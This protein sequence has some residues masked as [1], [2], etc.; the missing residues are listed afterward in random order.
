MKTAFSRRL[1]AILLVAAMCLSVMPVMVFAESKIDTINRAFTG[2]SGTSYTGFSGKVSSGSG[3]TYAGQCAGGNDSVQLRSSKSNSGIV[4][5]NSVGKAKTIEVVWNTNTTAGRTLDVYG[6]NTPYTSATELYNSSTQGTKIGSI[7]KGTSVKLDITGDYAYIGLRSNNGAMY[8]DS[9]SI[10][11]DVPGGTTCN[12]DNKT[13][14]VTAEATC[15][16]EGEKKFTCPDCNATWTEAIA[17]QDH[18]YDEGVVTKDPTCTE[19]GVKTYTCSVCQGTRTEAILATGHTDTDNDSVCDVCN[20]NLGSEPSA[21]DIPTWDSSEQNYTNQEAVTSAQIADGIT[22][23]FDKGT[24]SNAPKYYTS[25]TAIRCY[26]G[27]SFTVTSTKGNITKIV[28]GFGSGDGTNAITADSGTLSGDT[29][30][31]SADSVKFTIGG[32]S[33]NRRIQTI[34]VTVAGTTEGGGEGGG[35]THVHAWDAGTVTT[36]ATCTEDGVKTFTCACGQTRTEA[37]LA[38]GHTDTDNDSVCDV[39]NANLG[40]EP[41]GETATF[42]KVTTAPT[43]WSGTYLIV[44]EGHSV[45]LDGTLTADQAKNNKSVTISSNKIEADPAYSFSVEKYGENYAIK[46]ASGRYIYGTSGSNHLNYDSETAHEVTIDLDLAT[47]DVK[48]GNSG[49]ALRY[50]KTSGQERFRFYDDGSQEAIQLYK[51]VEPSEGA[52]LREVSA[53]L[54]GD[55][56][57]NYYITLPQ[58]VTD[59]TGAYVQFTVNGKPTKIMVNSISSPETDGSYKFTYRMNAKEMHDQVTFAVYDGS[60]NMIDL[61]STTG[62]KVE[63]SSFVYSLADYFKELSSDTSPEKAA[64]VNLAN[65][66]LA[67]GSYVQKAF[68]YDVPTADSVMDISGVTIDTLAAHKMIK[69]GEIPAGLTLSEMT[70]I[71]ETETTL[72][73]YFKAA[74]MSK[75]SFTLDGSAV[76]PEEI[77]GEGLYCIK[78]SNISAKDLDTSHTLVINGNCTLTFEALSYAYSAVKAGNN[79][80]VCDAVK[81]LYKYNEAANAY[82]S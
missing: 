26:G 5:T 53:T 46:S 71:L 13:F 30:T 67:Y 27:N 20:A 82:F 29:W 22:V 15:T 73:L 68:G 28:L 1:L 74:D 11:W 55:I 69:T 18:S 23:A 47:G 77:V 42:E 62:N 6:K 44:C 66:T 54:Q 76:T 2:V 40:S 41:S 31:G 45:I 57:M 50:N 19:D 49:K 61:Y 32:T 79:D 51:L 65:A 58:S 80:A 17:K 60:G 25:G 9:I 10:T 63:G 35:E 72:C 14:E 7:V 36:D 52:V 56:G 48:I 33:G 81:A 4:V 8:L 78:I 16:K 12:H 37:I 39:C 34:T 64:L 43:D 75:Y 59:D 24:N 70:L 3:T 21:E 38:T